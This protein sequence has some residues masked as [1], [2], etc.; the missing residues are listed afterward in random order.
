MKLVIDYREKKLISLLNSVKLMNA[1]YKPIEILVEN[2][3]LSDV[4][5]KDDKNNEKLLIERKTINDLASSIQDG[6][7][8]EQSYRLTNCDIHNHNIMYLIEGNISMWN[9]KYTRINRDTIYSAI[10]SIMYYKG[11]TTF[12]TSTTVE[13][14]EFLLNTAL[15]IHKNEKQ[16]SKKQP[17]YTNQMDALSY[18]I[19]KTLNDID[20]N[21]PS[22]SQTLDASSNKLNIQL[23]PSALKMIEDTSSSV[24]E[25]TP[26]LKYTKYV[27][28]EKKS[29]ITPENIDVIMLSQIPNVSVD[30]AIQII[31]KYKT[32]YNLINILSENDSELKDFKIKTKSGERRLNSNVISYI[33]NYL[34][35]K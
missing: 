33:K 18:N 30:T 8:N 2:L 22:E 5:I 24:A 10:F 29:N 23:N 3:P 7:Y 28:R 12:I 32:I 21:S 15:K 17:Y 27:K 11:F 9:N 34:V 14:A 4:I 13:T 1:K 20:N 6:R 16:S 25:K 31:D 19:D 26:D 35:D